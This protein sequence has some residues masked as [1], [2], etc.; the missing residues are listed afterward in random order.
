[1]HSHGVAYDD[2]G[3]MLG[4]VVIPKSSEEVEAEGVEVAEVVVLV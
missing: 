1:M 2:L 4:M 3:I